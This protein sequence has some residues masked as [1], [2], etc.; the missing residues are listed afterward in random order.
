MVFVLKTPLL[1]MMLV[2]L[3]HTV[4]SDIG[5]DDY[6]RGVPNGQE[7]PVDEDHRV[8]MPKLRQ[9]W[10]DKSTYKL[11]ECE[12]DC[13]DS[14]HCE[15]G[16]ECFSRKRFEPV[17]GCSGEGR[18]NKDCERKT[19]EILGIYVVIFPF[20]AQTLFCC[21]VSPRDLTDFLFVFFHRLHQAS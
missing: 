5:G 15:D 20:L 16:L 7:E 4:K 1:G 8:L 21:P 6:L 3:V 11:Q 12:G 2:A 9:F 17:P 13:D 14:S 19:R 10:G 18:R